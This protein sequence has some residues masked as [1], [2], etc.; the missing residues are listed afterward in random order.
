ME[1]RVKKEFTIKGVTFSVGG[2]TPRDNEFEKGL[3]YE[4]F[5]KRE[6][7]GHPDG[8]FIG[9]GARFGTF[10]AAKEYAEKNISTWL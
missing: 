4:L 8:K 1:G 10:R 2:Y 6:W 3:K 9:T 5:V 7:P